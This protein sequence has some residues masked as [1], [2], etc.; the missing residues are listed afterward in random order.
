MYRL[1]AWC[2][3]LLLAMPA[4]AGWWEVHLADTAFD[5]TT[6]REEALAVVRD[7]PFS[8]EAVG[9]ALWW[10]NTIASLRDPEEMLAVAEFPRDP[11]LGFLVDRIEAEELCRSC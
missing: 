9:A 11:E 2:A 5:L 1:A 4:T 8:A 10:L 6:A 3:M 7:D